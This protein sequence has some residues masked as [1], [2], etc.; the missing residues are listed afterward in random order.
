MSKNIMEQATNKVNIVGKLMDCTFREGVTKDGRKYEG[1]NFTVR[2]EQTYGGQT[3]ISEIPVSIFATQVTNSGAPHPGYKNIQD[4]KTL[5]TIQDY[6][7][8][9]ASR[10][11]M[12]GANIRENAFYSKNS[13]QLVNNWQIQT[14]FLNTA[15]NASDIAT[16]NVDIF[17]MDMHDEMDRDGEPTGRLVVKGGIV[18]YGGNLDVV[19]FL[20][21]GNDAV[22][23]ISRNW[24]INDTVNAG[25][26]IRITSKEVKSTAESGSWGEDLP[27]TSTRSVR[28]LIITR[29]SDEAFD[30]DFAY[31]TTDIKKA[32]NVRKARMEQLQINAKQQPA[33]NSANKYSWE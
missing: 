19:E 30:E 9:D 23:Y 4:L 27:E 3:E 18:Q 17:I 31:D 14:S 28:E 8:A 25:G 13:G 1:A 24:N 2:V 15:G 21:E 7:E 5:R 22:D 20:V 26:R 16:F 10:I 32:F 33:A 29:G 12:T 6:G 11:R